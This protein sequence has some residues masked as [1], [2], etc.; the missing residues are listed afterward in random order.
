MK[1][2][3][4]NFGDWKRYGFLYY[5]GKSSNNESNK[6]IWYLVDLEMTQ[7]TMPMQMD[8]RD[9]GVYEMKFTG[10]A[11]CQAEG[12]E[13]IGTVKNGVHVWFLAPGWEMNSYDTLEELQTSEVARIL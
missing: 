3:P 7:A 13:F 8:P 4:E 12:L 11:L 10:R 5:V 9:R 6:S 2:T 1:C